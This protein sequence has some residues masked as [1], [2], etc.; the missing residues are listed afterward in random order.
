MNTTNLKVDGYLRRATKW[1]DELEELRRILVDCD[2][3]EELKWG[4]PCYTFQDSNIIIIGEFKECCVLSFIKGALLKDSHRVLAKPGENS[5]SARVIRFTT[6]RDVVKMEPVLKAYI[7]E[8]IQVE[9][10]GLKVKLK[11]ITERAIPAELQDKFKEL[12]A[13][14]AAFKALT[15]GRQRA[16]YLYFAAAKQSTTRASRVEKC[17]QRILKGKGLNDP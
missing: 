11:K 1:R 12:P 10:A 6:V 5:Q 9:K 4:K 17:V 7:D 15:P 2:L 16:Y 8:A 14:K 3:T 13:L